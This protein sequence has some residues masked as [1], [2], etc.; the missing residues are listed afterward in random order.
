M[1]LRIFQKEKYK[2]GIF[3]KKKKVPNELDQTQTKTATNY[4]MQ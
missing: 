1:I 2:V 4:S 3:M